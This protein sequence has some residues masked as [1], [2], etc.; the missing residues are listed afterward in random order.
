MFS[1]SNLL[2]CSMGEID[3]YN[4]FLSKSI[5]I[6]NGFCDVIAFLGVWSEMCVKPNIYGYSSTRVETHGVQSV[7]SRQKGF[8]MFRRQIG[9]KQRADTCNLPPCPA[10]DRRGETAGLILAA[11]KRH[12]RGNRSHLGGQDGPTKFPSGGLAKLVKCM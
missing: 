1:P 4:I 8:S 12:A 6:Q 10:I 5:T 7:C 3:L 2:Q 11:F 9:R